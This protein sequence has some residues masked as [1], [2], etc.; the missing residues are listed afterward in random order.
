MNNSHMIKR[1]DA[2]YHASAAGPLT[3]GT[4]LPNGSHVLPG[5]PM[6][7]SNA[8]YGMPQQQT[9]AYSHQNMEGFT[10]S[11]T[12]SQYDP[13]SGQG[14]MHTGASLHPY[15]CSSPGSNPAAMSQF[16]IPCSSS[17]VN[18]NTTDAIKVQPQMQQQAG[19]SAPAPR[20]S[21]SGGSQDDSGGQAADAA[22]AQ[23]YR[24]QYRGVS[25]DKKKRK[26]RVQIKVAAL[27]K[28]GVSVGYFDTEDA[29][30]RAYDRAAIGLLGR[31]NCR[32]ILNFPIE[33]Y[34]Q[35]SVPELVGK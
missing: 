8:G 11:V 3:P 6:G 35:D 13:S 4:W 32:A 18:N 27:G 29:A 19:P 31:Q 7:I 22:S 21:G 25:Y 9:G 15:G 16:G 10:P 5:Y 34:D 12:A 2:Q 26:W 20:L 1:E 28:S 17:M 33:D 24:S 23:V 30:A 14:M